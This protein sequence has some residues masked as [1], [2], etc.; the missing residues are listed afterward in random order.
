MTVG[1]CM[2]IFSF[3]K[4]FPLDRLF[5][6]IFTLWNDSLRPKSYCNLVASLHS[7]LSFC[8]RYFFNIGKHMFTQLTDALRK[9]H[10]SENN[11][12][13]TESFIV[14]RMNDMWRYT[15]TNPNGFV[16]QNRDL[17]FGLRGP[18]CKD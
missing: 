7:A 10:S 4:I 12:L 5:Q 14:Q 8:V 17:D 13:C 16:I 6:S 1:N 18:G 3:I 15:P 9:Y 2:E 11:S